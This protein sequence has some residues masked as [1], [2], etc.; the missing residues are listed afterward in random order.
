MRLQFLH[1]VEFVLEAD[2]LLLRVVL[3]ARRQL[4]PELLRTHLQI[5]ALG[6]RLA[7]C[8]TA[9]RHAT[10]ARAMHMVHATVAVF[11]HIGLVAVVGRCLC[12]D[13]AIAIRRIVGAD[14]FLCALK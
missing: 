14:R 8:A 7:V 10:I 4:G 5:Q 12:Y 6:L 13:S 1:D 2:R 3:F 9:A 11:P